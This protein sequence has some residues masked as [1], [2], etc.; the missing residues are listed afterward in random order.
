MSNTSR[1][2]IG[3]KYNPKEIEK[4]WYSVWEKEQYFS[5][6]HE[7]RKKNAENYSMVIPPPNV[8]G[9]LHL[10]HALNH[11]LQDILARYQRLRGKKV[12]WLP[13]TDHAGIATQNVVEKQ[14]RELNQD[15]KDLGRVAFEE[16]V[17]AWKEKSGGKITYQQRQLGESVDWNYE[18]FT[19]DEDLSKI[20]KKSFIQ[21]YNE[22]LIYRGER[23]INWCPKD[24]TALSNIEVEYREVNGK[25]YTFKYPLKNGG[26]L[27]VATTRPETMLGDMALAVHPEDERYK[28]HIGKTAIVPFM[29]REIPI[30]A[31]SYVDKDYGTGVVKVTPAHDPNDF[32]MGQRHKLEFLNIMTNNARINAEGGT[33]EG[34]SR[35][36][37]RKNLL[38]NLEDASQ[39]IDVKEIKHSVGHS[40]RSGAVIEPRLSLQWFVNVQ[41]M[42]KRAIKAVKDGETV[43]YPERWSNT[44]FEWLNNIQDWCIS[45]QLW[46][47]HRIPAYYCKSCDHMMVLDETPDSCSNCQSKEIR[48]DQ[49]VLD[50]WFSSGMWPYSTLMNPGPDSSFSIPGDSEE[51]STFYPTSVLITGFDIIFFWVARM[52][53]FGLHFTQK[54]PFKH[55]Y[56]HG[57]VRDA[58]RQKMSK[59]KGNVIDPLEKM[60]EYGTDAFRFFL[61]SILPEGKDIIFDESRLN[62]YKAFCNKIWN[63]ARFILMN[64]KASPVTPSPSTDADH[65]IFLKYSEALHNIESAL[66]SYRFADYAQICYDFLWKDFCDSY[67]EIAKVQLAT[68]KENTLNNLYFLFNNILK[69]LHP[70]MPF[71]TEE[72]FQFFKNETDDLLISNNWSKKEDFDTERASYFNK[73]LNAVYQIRKLRADLKVPPSEKLEA[74]SKA[75]DLSEENKRIIIS[76]SR[77]EKLT[78]QKDSAKHTI[79]VLTPIGEISINAIKFIDVEAEKARIGKEIQFISKG[80]EAAEKKLANEKFRDNAPKDLVD[81]EIKKH[82]EYTEKLDRLRELENSLNA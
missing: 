30:V 46:W 61:I 80:F 69:M 8:T 72:L 33:F 58:D 57:L 32:E 51:L 9:S 66:E 12:L 28:Q 81:A 52:M 64:G 42:A 27:P 25:L 77:L 55:V 1:I 71:I 53:M 67:I 82:Q 54:V 79:K 16:K 44:Y 31:D 48:Q 73:I 24:E 35:E 15:R 43:F 38:K 36:E 41:P 60:T 59:S 14:L 10:G 4:D 50:T 56:I 7:S 40:Y 2:E 74:F 3:S 39:L 19:M 49:D 20:V 21:L 6:K 34:Q 76:L 62:G 47:G 78:E 22:G 68:E 45:R 37:C 23:M 18:K 29:N 70:I 13:G 75:S 65:W 17:W 11:T 63:T 26:F 5:W